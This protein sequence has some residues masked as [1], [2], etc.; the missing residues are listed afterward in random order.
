MISENG[1]NVRTGY[2]V[3]EIVVSKGR[4][5]AVKTAAGD[6]IS[7]GRAIIANVTT[8]RI[9]GG[10][11]EASK[12]PSRFVKKA[13]AFKYGP[14]TFI[15]HLA[16]ESLPVWAAGNDI[17]DF[18]YVHLNT[19]QDDIRD[20]YAS[21]I[22]GLLPKQPLLV[23][24]QT[25][26]TDPSRAPAGKHVMRVHVR[27]VPGVILGDSIGQ[28]TEKDWQAAR[29][30]F[31][32][33][34]LGQ[35]EQAIP[36]LRASISAVAIETPQDI[37]REN[38]NFVG[39]DCV[40]GSHHLGQNFFFRPMAGWSNYKT[41]IDGLFMIGASTWPGGG[42]NGSSGYMVAQRLLRE[43]KTSDAAVSR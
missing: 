24:S 21:C 18:S 1:G 9:F 13:S 10:L 26:N 34:V 6:E 27:T 36:D 29:E 25:T 7:A 22:R 32:E 41:P 3:R 31:A 4:A 16:L 11:V 2:S 5:V 33:R 17:A 12:L 19:A 43:G 39:G 38:P 23:V 42:V 20:T 15:I 40:S 28:I 35:V 8:A 37:E 14:G 30:P